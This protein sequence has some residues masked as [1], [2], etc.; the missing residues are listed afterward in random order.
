[1]RTLEKRSKLLSD[2]LKEHDLAEP[3]S[4]EYSPLVGCIEARCFLNVDEQIVLAGGK[5]ETGWAFRE[6]LD[7]SMYTIAHAIWI[8]P[9]R[10]RMDITPW[11]IPP[12]KRVLFLPDSRV[13]I[14]RGY[15]AGYRTV[16]SADPRIRSM[17]LYE[18]ELDR[19]HDEFFIKMGKEFR[20]PPAR[21]W[22]AAEKVGFPLEMAQLEVA[23]R[24]RTFGH[25]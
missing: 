22:E 24:Q 1:M 11:P 8:T 19:I 23:H 16:Y 17:E 4:V 25:G 13:A 21:F 20:I 7:I 12:D 18:L 3:K 15:T 9:Q 14:K 6:T 2:F 10:R 5:M